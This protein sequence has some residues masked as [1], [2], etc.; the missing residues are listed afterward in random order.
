M[1]TAMWACVP[2][3]FPGCTQGCI[4]RGGSGGGGGL[5]GTPPPPRVPLWSPLEAGQKFLT[6]NSSW[7]RRAEAKFWL[8]ASTVGREGEGGGEK[9]GAASPWDLL[10]G[11]TE[12]GGL[13]E[14]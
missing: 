4:R 14:Y 6:L 2:W 8:S 9:S 11:T 10:A 13:L 12:G 3:A 5:A 7:H 1:T